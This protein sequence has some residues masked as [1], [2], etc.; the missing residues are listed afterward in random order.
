MLSSANGA[1]DSRIAFQKMAQSLGQIGLWPIP[2]SLP[3]LVYVGDKPGEATGIFA[4]VEDVGRGLYTPADHLD[5]VV[6]S[7]I[8]IRL[9]I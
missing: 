9:R 7:A 4:V 3:R 1:L 6:G 2:E 8:P 5:Q